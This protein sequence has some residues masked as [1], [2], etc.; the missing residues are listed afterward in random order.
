ML[1]VRYYFRVLERQAGTAKFAAFAAGVTG[2]ASIIQA[3]LL[4]ALPS[5]VSTPLGP[6]GYIFACLVQFYLNIPASSKF[7][8]AGFRLSDKVRSGC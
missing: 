1:L 6:Y 3:L 5:E 4:R 7:T 2:V 8:V